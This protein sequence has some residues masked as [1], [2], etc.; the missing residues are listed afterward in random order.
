VTSDPQDASLDLLATALDQAADLLAEVDD[1]QLDAAT[2]CEEWTVGA[3]VDHLVN[4]PWVFTTIMRGEQPDWS[5]TPEHVGSDRAERFRAAGAAL[6]DAWRT[7]GE[8]SDQPSPRAW[9]LAEL[10]VHSWDLATALGA[11]T[12]ALDPRPAEEGLA[13]M[14][15]SL[16]ADNRG[17][18]FGPEQPAPDGADAYARIAAFAGRR[19]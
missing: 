3:L 10:S 2:P 5:A 18:V 11:S 14:Q 16:T 4:A 8:T 19:S 13:F 7:T 6:L 1:D 9:Q 12:A 15:A 17:G